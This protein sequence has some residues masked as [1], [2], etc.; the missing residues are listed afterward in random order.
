MDMSTVMRVGRDQKQHSRSGLR[1]N[2]GIY[3]NFREYGGIIPSFS[4]LYNLSGPSQQII[5]SMVEAVIAVAIETCWSQ[6]VKP[7]T[8]KILE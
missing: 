4:I 6:N 7:T 8:N 2:I 5:L 1:S 3:F